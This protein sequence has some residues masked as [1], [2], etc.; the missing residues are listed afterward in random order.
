M[1]FYA[2]GDPK[3]REGW[4]TAAFSDLC[5]AQHPRGYLCSRLDGHEPPHVADGTETIMAV[6]G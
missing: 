3:L 1:S 6:W 2:V 5:D 4:H